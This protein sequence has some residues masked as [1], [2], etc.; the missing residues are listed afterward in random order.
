MPQVRA[1]AAAPDT[2]VRQ[3][4]LHLA[5]QFSVF[6]GVAKVQLRRVVQLSMALPE[7]KGN[8]NF[9]FFS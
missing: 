4:L 3:P 6:D 2:K 1:A 9:K 7:I 8:K 5:G